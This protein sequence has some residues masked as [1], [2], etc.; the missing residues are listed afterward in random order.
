MQLNE[1]KNTVL[2]EMNQKLWQICEAAMKSAQNVV[3]NNW[4][5]KRK[6]ILKP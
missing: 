6:Q 4:K 2:K 1:N 5:N 3:K